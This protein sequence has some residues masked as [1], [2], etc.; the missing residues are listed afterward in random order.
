MSPPKNSRRTQTL[1]RYIFS[2]L[3]MVKG[4]IRIDTPKNRLYPCSTKVEDPT[5][6]NK[7]RFQKVMPFDAG[8]DLFSY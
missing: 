5:G 7:V 1:Y 6:E 2:H 4:K 3:F 8:S